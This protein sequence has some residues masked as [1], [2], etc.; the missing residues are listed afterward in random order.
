MALAALAVAAPALSVSFGA[1]NLLPMVHIFG[2]QTR[3][4]KCRTMVRSTGKKWK[5]INPSCPE[6]VGT[7]WEGKPEFCPI[8]SII[9]EPDVTLPGVA[10]RALIQAEVRK[11]SVG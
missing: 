5:I 10:E 8:L 1:G 4:S 9:V 11:K 2:M 7:Q 6:L 3:C